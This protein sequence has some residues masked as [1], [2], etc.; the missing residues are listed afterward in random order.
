MNPFSVIMLRTNL[1]IVVVA[2]MLINEI[3]LD[4]YACLKPLPDLAK[5][6]NINSGLVVKVGVTLSDVKNKLGPQFFKLSPGII[7][8]GAPGA[9]VYSCQSLQMDNLIPAPTWVN[10][11]SFT[12]LYE[13]YEQSYT[14]PKTQETVVP[15]YEVNTSAT[16]KTRIAA[17]SVNTVRYCCLSKYF[18]FVK[19]ENWKACIDNHTTMSLAASDS[20]KTDLFLRSFGVL[21]K[22]Y[23]EVL[24]SSSLYNSELQKVADTG[25]YADLKRRVIV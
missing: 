14:I 2:A 9:E 22:K 18:A 20:T 8:C 23:D 19:P 5:D 7:V 10:T 13:S 12:S 17:G 11:G 6:M 3:I 1:T 21:F 15:L 24:K 4:E 25:R 16:K